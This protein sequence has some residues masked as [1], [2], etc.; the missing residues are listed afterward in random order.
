M[1]NAVYDVDFTRALPDPLKNDNTMLALGKAIAG[2][3]QENIRLSRLAI[4]YARLDELDEPLLDILARDFHVDWYEDDYPVEAKRQV[5]KDSVKVHKRLGTKYAMTTALGSVFPHT[6]VQEW[7]EYGGTH[8]RFRIIL[9]FTNAKAP[10]DIFQIIRTQQF[11]K[12]LTAHLD[13]IIIQMSAVVEISIET[14]AYR[15]KNGMTGQYPAG[16]MPRRNTRGGVGGAIITVKSEGA[17]YRYEAPQTGTKP[18]RSTVAALREVEIIAEDSGRG[19][20]H[21]FGL[22]DQYPAGTK[23]QRN[24]GGGVAS[25]GVEID[26]E[27]AGYG[28]HSP[29]TGTKPA[30]NMEFT[31]LDN[32]VFVDADT[33]AFLFTSNITGQTVAGTKP[34]RN[35]GGAVHDNGVSADVDAEAFLYTVNM[36]GQGAA[37]TEPRRFADGRTT[38]GG[39]IPVIT[40][41]IFYYRVKRCGTSKT[42]N[43]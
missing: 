32:D 20:A 23:P 31:S 43:S 19:Y 18:H 2:E 36:T 26:A 8:H 24:T 12:R 16:T 25:G 7:Y 17:D 34:H 39:L 11:C 35:E 22:T 41:E 28:Y 14:T 37:G 21:R 40:A 27:G 6:E 29:S 3:L 5:I 38:P 42:K 10:A 9:D 15:Y 1:N 33:E 4:I 13:E 30:R